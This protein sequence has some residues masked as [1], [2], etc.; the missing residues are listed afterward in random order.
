VGR[1]EREADTLVMLIES[2]VLQFF[3]PDETKRKGN[4]PQGQ[5]RTEL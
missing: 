5:Q 1:V 3:Y 4:C 2:P